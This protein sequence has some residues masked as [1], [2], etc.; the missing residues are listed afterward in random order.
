M[1]KTKLSKK[2][3]KVVAISSVV[4]VFSIILFLQVST[5]D[6]CYIMSFGI[7]DGYIDHQ[8]NNLLTEEQRG[9]LARGLITIEGFNPSPDYIQDAGY[10][11]CLSFYPEV[12]DE[13]DIE[14]ESDE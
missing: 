13:I 5:V 14:F 1:Y 7:R 12:P 10:N 2:Q 4:V 8:I 11:Y 3:L 9:M 6:D